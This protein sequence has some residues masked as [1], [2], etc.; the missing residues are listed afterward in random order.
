MDE[1]IPRGTTI[2]PEV[3][4][5]HF[6]GSCQPPRGGGIAGYGFTVEGAH[7]GE[8][9]GLAVRPGVAHA[10]NNVAEYVGAIRALEWLR[11]RGFHG[12]VLMHGDSQL[13]IRQMNGEYAVKAPHLAAYHEQLQRLAKEFLEV[14]FLWIPREENRRADVLSKEAV[15]A[16]WAREA[17]RSLAG[18]K[19][20][21]PGA[22]SGQFHRTV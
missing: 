8:E 10:T 15:Q 19:D 3:A 6:D 16:V 2:M 1:K 17:K 18:L 5:V 13:V 21:D 14:R 22:R 12:A 4:S 7:E 9:H 20:P 11:A